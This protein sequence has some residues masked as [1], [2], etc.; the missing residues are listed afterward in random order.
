MV[1]GDYHNIHNNTVFNSTGKNDIIFLTDSGINNKNSTLHYNAVDE[2][3]DH[4]SD[5]VFAYPLPNGSHWNNWNGY[6]QGY[7]G[8]FEARNQISCAIYDNGSLYC[9][10]RNDHGQLGLG[11][12]GGREEVPQFVD[13]GNGR[14]ITSLGMGSSGAEGWEPNSHTCAVLDNGSLMCWGANGDGQLGIGNISANGVWE[15]T[16]VNVGSG[17]TAISVATAS[18]SSCALLNNQSV[19]CWGRNNLVNLDLVTLQTMM[20]LHHIMLISLAQASP[21]ACMLE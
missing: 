14:T 12:A 16:F 21:L 6:L 8:M 19:K 9:W 2:M 17:V 13:F 5:D 18:S 10:G 7:D 11:S 4:R 15:P 1:K 3:A 20:Y